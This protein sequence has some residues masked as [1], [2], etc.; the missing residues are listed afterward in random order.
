MTACAECGFGYEDLEVERIAETLRGFGGRYRAALP[1]GADDA[2]LRRRPAPQ[3]WS[4]LEYGCHVRDM[5][6]VQRDR[7]I[8]ALVEERPTFARMHRDERVALARY[9]EEDPA[10]VADQLAMAADLVATLYAGLSDRQLRRTCVYNYP[11][12]AERDVAWVGRHTL[13]EGEHHLRDI[14]I[15]LGAWPETSR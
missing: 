15:G 3:V 5:F 7:V 9:A 1:V 12:P 14:R 2:A 8:R 4:A 10:A 11:A 6:L 13:H